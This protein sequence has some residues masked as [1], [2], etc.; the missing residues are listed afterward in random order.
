[1]NDRDAKTQVTEHDDGSFIRTALVIDPNDNG[2]SVDIVDVD[3]KL[4]AR[5]NVF[6]SARGSKEETL[7]V[8]VI[9]VDRR[10]TVRRGLGFVRGERRMI[11]VGDL[12]GAHF[13]GV[14]R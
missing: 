11:E 10:Y 14:K 4:L 2:G 9:D 5:V 7:M 13:E 12:V 8:D 3:G 1:M 6:L